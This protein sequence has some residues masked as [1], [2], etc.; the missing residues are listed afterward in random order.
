LTEVDLS[1]GTNGQCNKTINQTTSYKTTNNTTSHLDDEITKNTRKK[2]ICENH[3]FDWKKDRK[4][5]R[6][7]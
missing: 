4:K 6:R 3:L 7:V 5:Y 1:I 2:T